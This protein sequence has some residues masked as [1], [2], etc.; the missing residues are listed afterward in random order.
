MKM[1]FLVRG[2]RCL[3]T[4]IQTVP[5]WFR[6]APRW[7]VIPRQK[8]IGAYNFMK[9]EV[10]LIDYHGEAFYT[11]F[12]DGEEMT[13]DYTDMLPCKYREDAVEVSKFIS[14]DCSYIEL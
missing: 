12:V 13:S 3:A 11:V 4:I 6:W 14:E 8:L 1:V 5:S 9:V 2:E 7:H 10:K